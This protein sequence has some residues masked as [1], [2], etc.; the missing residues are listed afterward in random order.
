MFY[1][2]IS[3]YYTQSH[4]SHVIET[5]QK[6]V[7]K[8]D[9]DSYQKERENAIHYNQQVSNYSNLS[10][11]LA[12]EKDFS[13]KKYEDLL[14]VGGIGVMGVLKIPSVNIELPIYHGTGQD[15]L[16]VGVGHYRGSSLPIGGES[17]HTVLTG[18]RGLPSS[19]LL[20]DIDQLVAGDIFY[21]KTLKDTIAYE[22]D[23]IKTVL[24]EELDDINV[25]KGEDY[26][27]LVTCTPYGIN[28]HRLLVRGKRI[29]YVDLKDEISNE[30]NIFPMTLLVIIIGVLY[31]IVYFVKNKKRRH[32]K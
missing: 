24:P 32:K 1:P 15:E 13:G 22:V 23:Q 11:V 19:R 16:Q 29:A 27:T 21:V 5:Y 25:V 8:I 9:L 31:M 6:D 20:T 4:Q 7:E 30:V 3:N 2:S 28:T 17:T 26:C 12:N 14:D 18:H 10:G